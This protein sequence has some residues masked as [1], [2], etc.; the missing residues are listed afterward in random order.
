MLG[1][2]CDGVGV[3]PGGG[4][5]DDNYWSWVY[6]YCFGPSGP[7][8][9]TGGPWEF[10]RVYDNVTP[11]VGGSQTCD[12]SPDG[13]WGFSFYHGTTGNAMGAL[14][15]NLSI[16]NIPGYTTH[17]S[18][19]SA[20]DYMACATNPANIR[21]GNSWGPQWVPNHSTTFI[22]W[23]F[24]PTIDK[25]N[26]TG[27]TALPNP[28]YLGNPTTLSG[29]FTSPA[30]NLSGQFFTGTGPS[31]IVAVNPITPLAGNSAV[32]NY[33]WTPTAAG[34]TTVYGRAWNDG[35]AE[36][37][38]DNPVNFVDSPPRYACAGP[39]DYVAVTVQNPTCSVNVVNCPS[40]VRAGEP[41]T[42]S[43][44]FVTNPVPPGPASNM[45]NGTW[46]VSAGSA[47][48]VGSGVI[49]GPI[50]GVAYGQGF[51]TPAGAGGST[52]QVTLT[53]TMAN[54]GQSCTRSSNVISVVPPLSAWYSGG[55]GGDVVAGGGSIR[56]L[57]PVSLPAEA[58][59]YFLS[60]I[61]ATERNGVAFGGGFTGV[62][63]TNVNRP[64]WLSDITGSP[65]TQALQKPETQ[66][67]YMKERIL[68]RA[69]GA[70]T[71][72]SPFD[73]SS[74][75]LPPTN[76]ISG[77]SIY[78]ISSPLN[79]SG[80]VGSKKLLILADNTVDIT[81]EITTGAGGFLTILS[82]GDMRVSPSVGTA[83][84]QIPSALS[85][86]ISGVFYTGGVF[87]TGVDPKQLKIEGTVVGMGGVSLGRSGAGLNPVEYFSFRPDFIVTL[88]QLGLRNKI[89][90]ELIAQ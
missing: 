27:M 65:W 83:G 64:Q 84:N 24:Y 67:A 29:T 20:S 75:S 21:V 66:Y 15:R 35:V 54:G 87:S 78:R 14:M 34:A 3:T 28:V 5:G 12:R 26:V 43:S 81:G 16:P 63:A 56:S 90:Q 49:P 58:T 62:T 19:C 45:T 89:V 82:G 31:N 50:S 48:V 2:S 51:T 8:Q 79:V 88:T 72:S 32:M 86:H 85:P 42:C 55:G 61:P 1:N 7:W 52:T 18:V 6:G 69:P 10:L 44:G 40:Q 77:V 59:Q 68:A 37:R 57:V 46:V 33:A 22:T 41:F 80:N 11:G 76:T 73:L 25:P 74:G 9:F 38:P 60:D 47:S 17:Y 53:G 13:T 39:N 4:G 70:V 36:C 23:Y 71:I 30:G